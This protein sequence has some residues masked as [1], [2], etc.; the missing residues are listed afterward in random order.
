MFIAIINIVLDFLCIVAVSHE[1]L[2]ALYI[3]TP[4]V[5]LIVSLTVLNIVL[6]YTCWIKL[7]LSS[8][9]TALRHKNPKLTMSNGEPEEEYR[10]KARNVISF[11][12][13]ALFFPQSTMSL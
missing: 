12:C 5:L 1:K 10:L 9:K 13:T 11:I 3:L 8:A 2:S 7:R 6:V 4:G